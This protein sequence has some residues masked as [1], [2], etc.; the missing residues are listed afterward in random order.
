MKITQN[1][2]NTQIPFKAKFLYSDDLQKVVDYAME[3]GLYPK[4][5]KARLNIDENRITTRIMM[6]R[7][8]YNGKP[9][10]IFLRYK[11]RYTVAFP[12]NVEKDYSLRR[13]VK[14]ISIKEKNPLKFACKLIISNTF[15]DYKC[16]SYW[17]KCIIC[18]CMSIHS[19]SVTAVSLCPSLADTLTMSTRL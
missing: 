18:L 19:Q 10:V 3:N 6:N 8:S 12:N 16:T 13:Q 2:F 11:P 15:S 17:R 14:Y 1:N 7:D 5:Y 4:L 9:V